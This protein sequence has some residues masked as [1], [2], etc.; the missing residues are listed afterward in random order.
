MTR[1]LAPLVQPLEDAAADYHEAG[2]TLG[3]ERDKLHAAIRKAA[4]E[5]LPKTVITDVTGL[6]RQTIYNVLKGD[7]DA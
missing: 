2:A 7:T 4:L 1:D 5:G 6:G 3:A